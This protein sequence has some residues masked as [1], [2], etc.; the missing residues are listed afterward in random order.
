MPKFRGA[1]RFRKT[2]LATLDTS[3]LETAVPVVSGTSA[4]AM[5]RCNPPPDRAAVPGR[6][7]LPELLRQ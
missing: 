7:E 6:G 1:R 2:R 5:L 4:A 3:C